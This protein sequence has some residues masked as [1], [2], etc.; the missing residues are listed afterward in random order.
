MPCAYIN[1]MI[2]ALESDSLWTRFGGFLLLLLVPV[3]TSLFLLAIP[4]IA[5]AGS[6]M[7]SFDVALSFVTLGDVSFHFYVNKP[8]KILY[9]A[10][11]G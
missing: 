3:V 9:G 10:I 5:I 2:C 11:Y 4:L 6:V 8:I 1:S 7:F